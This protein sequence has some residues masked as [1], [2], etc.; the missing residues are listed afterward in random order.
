MSDFAT[1]VDAI[2]EDLTTNVAGLRDAIVHRYAP[3]D[4]EEL[5]AAPHERHLAVFPSAENTDVAEPLAT[6]S[7]QLNQ[8]YSVLYW[9]SAGDEPARAV[10]D[11]QAAADLLD[12]HNAVRARFYVSANE[13]LGGS[14]LVWYAA[15]GLAE[16]VGAVRWFLVGVRVV[17]VIG[18]T[19]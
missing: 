11:E 5:Q 18:F 10:L 13:S 8:V 14:T 3:W 15:S 19:E 12:L 16:R 6:G 4:P 17:R 2:I 9:E 7:H 1:V